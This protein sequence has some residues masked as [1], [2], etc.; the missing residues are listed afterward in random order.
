M[1]MIDGTILNKEA[2][3]SPHPKINLY[4]VTYYSDGLRVKGLLAEP[5]GNESLDGF[6]YLRGGIKNV[7]K[8]RAGRII[9][10]ASKGFVV[11]APF[12][13]GNQGGEGFE[14]F[15]GEDRKDAISAFAVLEDHPRVKKVHV[16]GFSRGGVMALWTA[17]HC[18]QAA[19]LVTWNGVS[20]LFLTYEERVDM[21]RMMKR[22][23]GGS[24]NK[25]PQSYRFRT[26]EEELKDIQCPVL[27]IH[28][29]L[30][31]NVSIEHSTNLEK[32]LLQYNKEVECWYLSKYKH[33]FPPHENRRMVEKLTNWMKNSNQK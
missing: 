33:H 30:D 10:F 13:R 18:P 1:S 25:N 15:A 12:Y 19:S 8:V 32:K 6:L 2:F 5:Q 14:D 27:I 21:R 4:T 23:L 16:F 3:P 26:P 29:V 11:F 31:G 20:D 24:P 7:G 9:E 28:G 22:V 17:I